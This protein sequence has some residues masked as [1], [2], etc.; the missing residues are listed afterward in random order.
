MM[1]SKWKTPET[2]LREPNFSST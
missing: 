1:K 2:K